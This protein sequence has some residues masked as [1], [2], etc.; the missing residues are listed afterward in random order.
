MWVLG[1]IVVVLVREAPLL[2]SMVCV[3]MVWAAPGR[4]GALLAGFIVLIAGKAGGLGRGEPEAGLERLRRDRS[5]GEHAATASGGSGV[6]GQPGRS[7]RA[8]RCA[9]S[10]V[11]HT[12]AARFATG[13][14]GR[15]GGSGM[16]G[17]V[18]G[19]GCLGRWGA[20]LGWAMWPSTAGGGCRSMSRSMG[21]PASLLL[22]RRA[23]MLC[24]VASAWL[25]PPS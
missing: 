4:R 12:A 16:W 25:C 23:G 9:G 20:S 19:Y 6:C 22:L 17:W 3:G 2:A 24:G 13:S 7:G 15:A 10:R 5:E 21:G 11:S 14:T 1:V 8:G 18:G